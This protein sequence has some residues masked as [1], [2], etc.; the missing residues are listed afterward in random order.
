MVVAGPRGSGRSYLLRA[1]AAELERRGAVVMNIRPATT[2]SSLPFGALRASGHAA[3]HE[4]SEGTPSTIDGILMID[5]VD[6]LDPASARA[7][8]QAVA[9]RR[10]TVVAGLRTARARSRH[11]PDDADEVR[12]TFLELWMDRLAR[13]IDLSELTDGDAERM[14]D[15][16]PDAELLD[17]PT[18]A[19]LAWRADGSRTLLRQL[20]LEALRAAR[21]GRDPLLATSSV[22]RD[23]RL[24]VALER[25]VADFLPEDLECLAGIRRLPHLELAVATRLFDPEAVGALRTAGLLH[26]DASAER[27]LTSNDLLAA[28]AHRQLGTAAVD[29]L[30]ERA[31]HRMLA[32]SDLWWSPTIAIDVSAR[33]HRLGAEGSDELSYRPETRLRVALAA[34]RDANDRGDFAHAAAHAARGLIAVDDPALRVEAALAREWADEAEDPES[35]TDSFSRR[36]LAR[37]RSRRA[38]EG[39]ITSEEPDRAAA[40]AEADAR[41]EHLL[42][43]ATRAGHRLDAEEACTMTALAVSIADASPLERLRALTA[44]GMWQ[45]VRGRWADARGHYRDAVR[46][47][48]ARPHPHGIS[49]RERL[50]ALLILLSGHQVAGADGMAAQHRLEREL[51][52][53]AREGGAPE[54][55]VAGIA[56]SVAFAGSGH[57]E[58]AHREWLSAMGRDPS[59]LSDPTTAMM[60]LNVAE[61]LALA[62]RLDEARA[63][64]VLVDEDGPLIVRRSRLYVETTIL[65]AEGRVPQA[66]Q[67]ARA[68]AALTRGSTAAALRI[69]DL[70]RLVTLDIADA[71]EV[72]ELV[73][74]AATTDLPLAA[75]AVR[76]ASARSSGSE[77]VMPIDEL[78]L[79][80]LWSRSDPAPV[81]STPAPVRHGAATPPAPEE[82]T[83]RERE[84]A[85]LADQGLTNREIAT[86]LFLSVRTVESHVYQARLKLG[87]ASRRELARM[88]AAEATSTGPATAT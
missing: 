17:M 23:S 58:Q 70:Y 79:H 53:A 43:A 10:L 32:E 80:G 82:L 26:A 13:R 59:A 18:R 7:I 27:R 4:L 31:G 74:L 20:V 75:E 21:G 69:R 71:D 3:L 51:S 29:A 19:G 49:A 65:V 61:E 77:D 55:T 41:V 62:G 9:T 76:R 8:A 48:D 5:D 64:L 52:P 56:A 60:R 36:R 11:R 72:D 88:V 28:E 73:Q 25:H 6:A 42:A 37:L 2:L 57:P 67:T 12:R 86:R 63:L 40:E 15:L 45:A 30:A 81:A 39:T 14:I 38:A 68:A 24:A 84:I 87:A 50:S 66:R 46:L 85:L 47:L 83:A 54:L 16:F 78:R 1:V 35:A 33:W 44:A 34:A 22:A